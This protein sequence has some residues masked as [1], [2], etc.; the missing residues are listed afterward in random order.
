[1]TVAGVA[2]PALAVSWPSV[3]VGVTLLVGLCLWGLFRRGSM[4][5]RARR[6][7]ADELD[8]DAA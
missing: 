8:D 5:D 7:Y 4:A 3:A 6:D 2:A 1:M